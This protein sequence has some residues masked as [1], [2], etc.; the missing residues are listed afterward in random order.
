MDR[1][2]SERLNTA[3][4][5]LHCISVLHQ[6]AKGIIG[7]NLRGKYTLL[8]NTNSGGPRLDLRY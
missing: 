2:S 5:P 8:S 7:A 3:E 1:D 4:H 6:R